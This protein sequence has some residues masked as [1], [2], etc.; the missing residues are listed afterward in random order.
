M[1]SKLI[2]GIFFFLAFQK[3]YCNDCSLN[4]SSQMQLDYAEKPSWKALVT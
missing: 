2:A 3:K 4:A 1:I